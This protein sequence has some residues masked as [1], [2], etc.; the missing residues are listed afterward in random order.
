[1]G[2]LSIS[3]TNNIMTQTNDGKHLE[4]I[5]FFFF[6]SNWDTFSQKKE[7]EFILQ[8]Y[9]QTCTYRMK[10]KLKRMKESERKNKL[11]IFMNKT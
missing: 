3:S 11:Y 5:C 1:M 9:K 4:I 10:F 2:Y 7:I 8:N 6:F